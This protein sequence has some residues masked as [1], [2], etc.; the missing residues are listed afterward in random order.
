MN[1]GSF[2]DAADLILRL[3]RSDFERTQNKATHEDSVQPGM[4]QRYC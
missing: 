3:C 4:W 2:D 1:L